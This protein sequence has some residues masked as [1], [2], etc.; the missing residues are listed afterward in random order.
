MRNLKQVIHLA[1]VFAMVL[2]AGSAGAQ[3]AG[4]GNSTQSL[5]RAAQAETKGEQLTMFR[6][7]DETPWYIAGQSN[8]IFQA[9]PGFHSPYQGPN[10]LL[11][12]GEYKTSLLGTVY[13]ADQPF[14]G[15]ARKQTP[16]SLRYNTDL[17]L[18]IES[19]GGRGLSEALGLAGFT[20]LDVVR[21]PNL[22]P[23]PYVARV[24]L[25]QTIGFTSELTPSARS[26][27]SLATNVPVRRLDLRV[28]KMS[29][30][31][32]FDLNG[33]LSDSHLQFM[34]W[35]VD[36]N[37][38]WDYAA[39]TRGYTYAATFA[40]H[41]RTWALRYGLALM[42]TVANGID[43]DWDL[44]RARGQNVEAEWQRSLIPRRQGTQRALFFLN[45]AHMGNYRE[46]I[47]AF[48][49]GQDPRPEITK[50][51]HFDTPK[52]GFGYNFEQGITE[53]MRAAGRFGWSD[54]KEESFAYTEVEQTV[55]LGADYDGTQWHRPN[56]R[57][58]VAFNSNAIKRDHQRY[59]ALGG[60][61]FLLGDGHL[62]YRREQILESYYN[63]HVIRGMYFG[64]GLTHIDNP[65]Y[66]HDRGPVWVSS[67]RSHV[68]F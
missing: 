31:D 1:I 14:R 13:L 60:L 28:G 5:K 66:N 22:G 15:L 4:G 19:A 11:P 23:T 21:N 9:H 42:P 20:N 10:S 40:Y 18:D 2:P 12:R 3:S 48:L 44:R 62:N 27:L 68:D 53:H 47:D 6:H 63:L 39:D 7:P 45:N 29:L 59:L 65:G 36:N 55:L 38:A 64:L 24:E 41:D 34:D 52:Y 51:A 30:P 25:H 46:A 54:G 8:I 49:S 61:G 35:T 17:I 33:V 43:L 67:V 26:P 32:V 56:D 37:G 57:I 58:G 16:R 50:H